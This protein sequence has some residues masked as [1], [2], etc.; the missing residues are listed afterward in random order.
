MSLDVV[1]VEV[2]DKPG[3]ITRTSVGFAFALLDSESV[4]LGMPGAVVAVGNV[5][6]DTPV[7]GVSKLR[8]PLSRS[9]C[10][11]TASSI[12]TPECEALGMVVFAGLGCARRR[13]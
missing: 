10:Q 5:P 6:T 9:L 7:R 4:S 8:N 12:M 1:S 11:A 3:M 2:P 13:P